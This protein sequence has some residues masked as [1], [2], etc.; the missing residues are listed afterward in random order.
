MPILEE[1]ILV[2]GATGLIGTNLTEEM[3]R[4]G[5]QG[6][7]ATGIEDGDLTDFDQALGLFERHR[8]TVLVHLAAMV[9]G[10]LA[11]STNLCDFYEVNTLINTHVLMAAKK[12]GVRKIHAMGTG[13]AY[14]KRLEGELLVEDDFLDG[15]PEPTN[16]AYAYAKR[17]ML[18]HLMAMRD[19]YGIPYTCLIPANI[20]GPHDNFHPTRSHVVPGLLVRFMKAVMEGKSEVV[21]WGTGNA[22]RDLLYIKD[23]VEAMLRII[24]HEDSSGVYNISSGRRYM[25]RQLGETIARETGFAGKLVFDPTCPDGQT[26][27]VMSTR[28][29]DELGWKPSFTLEQGIRSTIEWCRKNQGHWMVP[30]S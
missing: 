15:V 25:I 2:T 1:R 22:Q 26:T 9:G 4:R 18:V 7:V 20:F 19:Q 17:N 14:P 29:L 6:M 11:N 8:P 30:E 3:R 13:C 24:G 21:I 10:I 16:Y 27:R 5:Y 23:C 28:R 12:Y